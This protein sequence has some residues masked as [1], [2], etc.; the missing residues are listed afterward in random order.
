MKARLF[1]AVIFKCSYVARSGINFQEYII[2]PRYLYAIRDTTLQKTTAT[3][4]RGIRT[5]P[6]MRPACE[7]GVFM[8]QINISFVF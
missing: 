7:E 3:D 4:L 5:P 2:M 8:T 1:F 6:I